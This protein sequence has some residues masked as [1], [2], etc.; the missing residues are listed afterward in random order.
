MDN[1]VGTR[2]PLI[3]STAFWGKLSKRPD[4]TRSYHPQ[5]CHMID[6]GMVARA[7]LRHT[8]PEQARK[9]LAKGFGIPE[10]AAEPWI[11]FLAALHRSWQSL[12]R[13][14]AA[15][16]GAMFVPPTVARPRRSLQYGRTEPTEPTEPAK[17]C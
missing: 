5:L 3:P 11:T 14:P 16:T 4:E 6:V 13:F 9:H 10:Y 8:Y 12:T 1:E 17:V 15:E 2:G 7:M